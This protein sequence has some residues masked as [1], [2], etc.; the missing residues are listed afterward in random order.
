MPFSGPLVCCLFQLKLYPPVSGSLPSKPSVMLVSPSFPP[1]PASV[2]LRPP[3]VSVSLPPPPV[4]V[5]VTVLVTGP[6]VLGGKIAGTR[7]KTFPT[8]LRTSFKLPPPMLSLLLPPVRVS[9]PVPEVRVS[10]PFPPV[11]VSLP[12]PPSI[13]V[14]PPASSTIPPVPSDGLT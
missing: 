5:G 11:R 12:P 13:V 1:P 4:T 9:L 7:G 2:S 14:T 6:D 8:V 10:L 3:P